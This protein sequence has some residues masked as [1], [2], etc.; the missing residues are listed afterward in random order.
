MRQ[1]PSVSEIMDS[2]DKEVQEYPS[3]PPEVH[4]DAELSG[5]KCVDLQH[6]KETSLGIFLR[7]RG[8]RDYMEN[9][10]RIYIPA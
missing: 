7:A 9:D 4:A 6:F 5:N 1:N 8:H 10:K 2:S 3:T